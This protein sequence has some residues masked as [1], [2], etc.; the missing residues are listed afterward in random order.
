MLNTIYLTNIA[1]QLLLNIRC[2][3][4]YTIIVLSPAL[5]CIYNCNEYVIL[6]IINSTACYVQQVL[7]G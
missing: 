6:E 3:V 2:S 1:Y 7:A 5:N 4:R